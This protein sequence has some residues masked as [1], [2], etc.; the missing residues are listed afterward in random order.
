MIALYDKRITKKYKFFYFVMLL[1]T[2]QLAVLWALL[3]RL[4]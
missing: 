1:V 3:I 4:T 2:L